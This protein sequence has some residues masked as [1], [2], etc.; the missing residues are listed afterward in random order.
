MPKA[1][2]PKVKVTKPVKSKRMKGG[3]RSTVEAFGG[4]LMHPVDSLDDFKKLFTELTKIWN[5]GNIGDGLR[6]HGVPVAN[7]VI[8]YLPLGGIPGVAAATALEKLQLVKW[9]NIFASL[10]D[11]LNGKGNIMNFLNA[12]KELVG[13]IFNLLKDVV[14]DVVSHPEKITQAFNSVVNTVG[15]S[16][17]EAFDPNVRAQNEAYRR[18][19]AL[20]G[21]EIENVEEF[22]AAMIDD[23]KNVFSE[24][25][26]TNFS[27]CVTLLTAIPRTNHGPQLDRG[28]T[29]LGGHRLSQ[30]TE[31]RYNELKDMK[32]AIASHLDNG[33]RGGSYNLHAILRRMD[34]EQIYQVPCLLYLREHWADKPSWAASLPQLPA[35]SED[36]F[37][38]KAATI[39]TEVGRQTPTEWDAALVPFYRSLEEAC[40]IARKQDFD[41][42]RATDK[43]NNEKFLEDNMK[44]IEEMNAH[45]AS[46]PAK[47]KSAMDDFCRKIGAPL[48]SGDD[49]FADDYQMQLPA[50]TY[51]DELFIQMQESGISVYGPQGQYSQR[52]P[53]KE[54]LSAQW[55]KAQASHTAANY[56]ERL[57][58]KLGSFQEQ[59]NHETEPV[60]L[61]RIKR[62]EGE[63]MIKMT[64]TMVKLATPAV[65]KL[66]VKVKSLPNGVKQLL[67]FAKTL[68][69][70]PMN[71]HFQQK[72]LEARVDPAAYLKANPPTTL[73][74]A[75]P[76]PTMPA[77]QP[78][79]L[80]PPPLPPTLSGGG[81]HTFHHLLQA[82]ARSGKRPRH[83]KLD[84]FFFEG[85]M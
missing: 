83:E 58:V 82:A 7:L 72:F 26:P 25:H 76:A 1:R 78:P 6:Q 74:P 50:M 18:D 15:T 37:Y 35:W 56:L 62:G 22:K 28:P 46:R 71:D 47:Y 24:D 29:Q 43:A 10:I 19:Q 14:L 2:K 55:T 36:Q 23:A 44:H 41:D 68:P 57:G 4:L 51:E 27:E 5:N 39:N 63:S 61:E 59:H 73:P 34:I 42:A 67:D 70:G 32:A 38:N 49:P 69:P 79:P 12:L 80:A 17:V 65:D 54:E 31:A 81:M 77:F 8:K 85:T 75:L 21:E 20:Q 64:D 45:Q 60:W 33:E 48:I 11:F 9:I 52:P 40:E 3:A 66:I 13:D 84:P 30:E 16:I 53:T